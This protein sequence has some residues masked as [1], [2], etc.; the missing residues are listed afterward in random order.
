MSIRKVN[1]HILLLIGIHLIFLFPL[2]KSGFYQ[3]HDGEVQVARFAAYYKAFSDNHIPPRWAG[4]LNYTY[5]SPVLNFYYPLPGYLASLLHVF[6]ITFQD[7]FKILMAISFIAAPIGFYI[8]MRTHV[9]EKSALIGAIL[10]GLLPYHFLNLYVRGDIAEM[11]ALV[12]VPFIFWAIE[13]NKILIGGLS[14]ALLILSHNGISLMFTPILLA[15]ALIFTPKHAMKLLRFNIFV[16][17]LGIAAFFWLPALFEMRYTLGNI[18]IGD[19]FRHNFPT[20]TQL[21]YSPWGFGS[22]VVKSGGLSPQ[23]GPL[24]FFL[25]T[26]SIFIVKTNKNKSHILFW[27]AACLLGIFLSLSI[28]TPLWVHLPLLSK[29][30]FPWRFSALTSFAAAILVTYTLSRI[31]NA[32]FVTVIIICSIFLAYPMT[33][34]DKYINY[35]DSHYLSFP[36]TTYFHGE[37]IIKWSAG[38]ASAYPKDKIEIISG[39]AKISNHKRNTIMQEFTI[40]TPTDTKILVNTFYYPG[41]RVH[42]DNQ[43][44]PIE[45]QDPNHRGLITFNVPPGTHTI[46]LKFGETILRIVANTISIITIL[47]IMILLCFKNKKTKRNSQL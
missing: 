40:D 37:T 27:Q 14:Y 47:G 19:M 31:H 25:V 33:K 3:S 2:L 7:T 43:N 29:F 32:I 36:G 42:I 10:Y 5:G 11:V 16:L 34:I 46:L 39:E 21:I 20:L 13:K 30:Q 8:W 35:P 22:E 45:F 9:P 1:T 6:S 4:D 23:I 15:Y 28:S 18:F 41:W 38:D 44:T 12:F 26:L 17:G 24:I